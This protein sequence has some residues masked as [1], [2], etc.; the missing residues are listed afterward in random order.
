MCQLCEM[1]ETMLKA[2]GEVK[3]YRLTP[4]AMM[5]NDDMQSWFDM[6]WTPELM[7]KHDHVELVTDDNEETEI[8]FEQMVH[9]LSKDGQE[10]IEGLTP[11]SAHL[12]HMATG[13]AGEVGELI[14][15]HLTDS[16]TENR[17]EE[18]GD[19]EFYYEGI[20][21]QSGIDSTSV[22][23]KEAMHL[24]REL[25]ELSAASAALLD[26]AKKHA[27]YEKPVD[28]T[29][30]ISAMNDIRG[31]LNNLYNRFEI[32]RDDVIAANMKKLA[33]RYEGGSYS[34]DDA[35]KRADKA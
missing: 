9:D 23:R 1:L 25:L 21:A 3:T 26:A 4:I 18:L 7:I 27:V 34:N 29:A 13:V 10:I 22:Q 30:V 20:A 28:R 24:D 35:Q 2:S 8:T 14:E 33:V 11:Q 31:R 32:S 6:G 15:N 12:W 17:I 5:I 16:G 19:I